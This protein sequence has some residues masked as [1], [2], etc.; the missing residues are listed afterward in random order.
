MR[1]SLT[2]FIWPHVAGWNHL[3][4]VTKQPVSEWHRS[5]DSCPFLKKWRTVLPES[6]PCG[7]LSS[8]YQSLTW[9]GWFFC[10]SSSSSLRR[11]SFSVW[12]EENKAHI[13]SSGCAYSEQEDGSL[14]SW[15]TDDLVAKYQRAL[16]GV[17]GVAGDL[18]NQLQHRSDPWDGQR[19]R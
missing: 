16:G 1:L 8:V 10:T 3:H 12:C 17:L 18:A 15:H 7:G 19:L 6:S 13:F 9:S 11:M 2:C 5:D 14:K 4:D